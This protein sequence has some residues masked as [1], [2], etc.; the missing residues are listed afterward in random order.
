MT[1][2]L[3]ASLVATGTRCSSF[4][5]IRKSTIHHGFLLFCALTAEN[6]IAISRKKISLLVIE[7]NVRA[8]NSR[9]LLSLASFMEIATRDPIY[10]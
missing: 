3:S 4:A 5:I 9:T 7:G 10:H 2:S 6:E 8:R 1:N